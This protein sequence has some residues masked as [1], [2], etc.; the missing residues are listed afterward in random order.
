MRGVNLVA[1]ALRWGVLVETALGLFQIVLRGPR[2]DFLVEPGKGIRFLGTVLQIGN[3]KRLLRMRNRTH[4]RILF[5]FKIPPNNSLKQSLYN[6]LTN[7]GALGRLLTTGFCLPIISFIFRFSMPVEIK[8]NLKGGLTIP[9]FLPFVKA[10]LFFLL[11]TGKGFLWEVPLEFLGILRGGFWGFSAFWGSLFVIFGRFLMFA[12]SF[13][14]T[15]LNDS[16][17]RKLHLLPFKNGQK[18]PWFAYVVMWNFPNVFFSPLNK[19][20]SSSRSKF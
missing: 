9:S 7:S 15:N 2:F 11:I 6:F 17:F 13:S 8:F 18:T 10:S 5:P 3:Q 16:V 20:N 1:E 4:H 19:S 14:V 12:I